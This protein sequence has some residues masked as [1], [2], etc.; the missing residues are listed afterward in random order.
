MIGFAKRNLK[1]FF[2]DRRAVF[3]SILTI[4]IIISLYA[5]FLGD[6]WT[7]NFSEIKDAKSLMDHWIMAG[8]LAVT[9]V[10]TTLGILGIMVDDKY[11]G[12]S[13]DFYSSPVKRRSIGGGYIV[14]AFVVGVLMSVIA[15]VLAEVYIAV[16]GGVI[17]SLFAVV[18]IFALILLSSFTC[19]AIMSFLVSFFKSHSAY[20]AAG[21]I[22]GTLIGF[23]TGIY[24]PVGS[25][26]ESVQY[27][28]KIFPVS[29]SAA[30]FR[31]IFLEAPV[32]SAFANMPDEY[33]TRFKE[34]MGVS[35]SIGGHTIEP[36][37]SILILVA[38]SV[39]FYG[40]AIFNMSRK[41]K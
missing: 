22:I 17:L 15:L 39:V 29:H 37:M 34:V 25:L 2:R 16:S 12:I 30:L 18:K 24:L 41:S 4:I 9:P 35:Y 19:T 27:V 28:I 1:I 3:F 13:K 20:S 11:R 14:S 40:L 32:Q 7:G 21:N 6:V 10:T 26:P 38:T 31:Q 23:L 33:L 8:I 5:L 36:L